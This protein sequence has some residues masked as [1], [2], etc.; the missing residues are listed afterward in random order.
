[1]NTKSICRAFGAALLTGLMTNQAAATPYTDFTLFQSAAGPLTTDNFESAPWVDST[2]PMPTTSLGVAWTAQDNLFGTTAAARSGSRSLS[3]LD[4][5]QSSDQLFAAMPNDIFAIGGWVYDWRQ[6]GQISLTAYDAGNAVLDSVTVD[7]ANTL[8]FRF[9]GLTTTSAIASVKFEK[10][11]LPGTSTD[12]DFALD[13]FSFGGTTSSV[14][15]PSIIALMALG[16]AGI[17]YARK[18]NSA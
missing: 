1:M 7:L 5:T 16:L 12:D 2:N 6:G 11:V 3:D 14:P 9:L 4:G 15:E 17:G 10:L 13:D 18:K 8:D